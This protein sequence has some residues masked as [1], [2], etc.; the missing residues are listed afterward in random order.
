MKNFGL[1]LLLAASLLALAA[2]L[3]GLR[4][5]GILL[6]APPDVAIAHLS[7][8]DIARDYSTAYAELSNE[9]LHGITL[10][11]DA[12]GP[13]TAEFMGPGTHPMVFLL[14]GSLLLSKAEVSTPTRPAAADDRTA[15]RLRHQN[16]TLTSQLSIP[17]IP[18]GLL[19]TLLFAGICMLR[20]QRRERRRE[21]GRCLHCA[22]DLRVLADGRCPE[23]GREPPSKASP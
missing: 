20:W 17:L 19:G 9:G 16:M 10:T 13:K 18:I 11:L 2:G 15:R 23:C 14:R 12:K 6:Y 7:A 4:K 5:D 8:A 3:A 21:E 22:Y 1:I